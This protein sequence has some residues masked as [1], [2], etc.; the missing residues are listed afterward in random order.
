[1]KLNPE[2][3]KLLAMKACWYFDC[4]F[5]MNTDD[6]VVITGDGVDDLDSLIA[7]LEAAIQ[8]GSIGVHARFLCDLGSFTSDWRPFDLEDVYALRAYYIEIYGN[9]N[10]PPVERR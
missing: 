7:R 2:D 5:G 10:K 6:S 3:L 8:T 1:M 9:V 4:Y